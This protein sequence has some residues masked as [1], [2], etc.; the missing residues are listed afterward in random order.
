MCTVTIIRDPKRDAWR[1]ACNRDELRTRPPS[2]PPERRRCGSRV[3]IMPVDPISDGT[4]IAVNDAG[5]VLTLL[6]VNPEVTDGWVARPKKSH[7]RQSRGLII[8]KLMRHGSVR[9]AMDEAGRLAAP[10][11][12]PFRLV[13]LDGSTT[14]DLLSDGESMDLTWYDE[15]DLPL[16]FTSSGL[17]DSRVEAPRRALFEEHLSPSA[18]AEAQDAFHRHSWPDSGPLSVCMNREDALTVSYTVIERV[19][20]CSNLTHHPAAPDQVGAVTSYHLGMPAGC[21]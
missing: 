9:E 7:G 21:S 16:L 17:G 8:P 6:N 3:A 5:L 13:G 15:Q 10:S 19:G 11:Y 20:D 2:T 1:M 12:P 4:W 18:D 14:A